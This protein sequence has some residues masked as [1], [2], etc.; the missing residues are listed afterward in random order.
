[1]ELCDG[2]RERAHFRFVNIRER[3]RVRAG[4]FHTRSAH[5]DLDEERVDL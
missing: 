2:V 3:I 4:L 5:D 1:M